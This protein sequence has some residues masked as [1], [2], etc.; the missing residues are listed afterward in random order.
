MN[1]FVQTI[2]TYFFPRDTFCPICK[3]DLRLQS[4]GLCMQCSQLLPATPA[5]RKNLPHVAF[6]SAAF[7]YREPIV[8]LIHDYKYN[9]KRYLAHFFAQS[10]LPFLPE[11]DWIAPIP[12]HPQRKK[13]RGYSQT[14]LLCQEIRQQSNRFVAFSAFERIRYTPSQ[15]K[16]NAQERRENLLHAF[17]A[18]P[19]VRGKSICL[20][21]DVATTGS[22]INESAKALLAAGATRIFACVIAQ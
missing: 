22:T 3:T 20:I 8:S 4:N 10:M 6:I 2:K 11:C 9:N 14:D 5:I 21:D 15:T 12:L 17:R 18:Q 1:N 16:L 7:M 19:L 13:E